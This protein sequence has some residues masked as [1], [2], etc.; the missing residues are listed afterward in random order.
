MD[1]SPD[2]SIANP[3]DLSIDAA[4]ELEEFKQHARQDVPALRA[5]FHLIQ[6]PGPAFDKQSISMLDDV[7]AY[8]IFRDS[9]GGPSK[10]K[11][12]DRGE[13]KKFITRYLADLEAGV[14]KRDEKK[15]DEAKRFCISFNT[16]LIAKQ[17]NEVY[18]RRERADARNFDHE[19]V[20]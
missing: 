9:V 1:D 6:T 11:S 20:S 13:F 3:T 18:T 19:P 2:G 8:A 17:M 5:L 15:I 12:A 16:Y 4:L 10:T 14:A 7:R